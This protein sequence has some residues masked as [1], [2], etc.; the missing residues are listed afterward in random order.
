VGLHVEVA[1]DLGLGIGTKSPSVLVEVD[2]LARVGQAGASPR[3]EVVERLADR[4]TRPDRVLAVQPVEPD[5]L[6]RPW[7]RV[8][9]AKQDAIGALL[10]SRLRLIGDDLIL[11]LLVG[12]RRLC[13]LACPC[14]PIVPSRSVA[15]PTCAPNA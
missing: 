11:Q 2:D 8:R 12:D 1:P 10:V 7:L 3:L 6:W 15:A 13:K 14:I 9:V 4:G 5:R